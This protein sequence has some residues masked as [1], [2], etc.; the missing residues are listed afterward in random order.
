MK[1]EGRMLDRGQDQ[2]AEPEGAGLWETRAELGPAVTVALLLILVALFLLLGI[3][4]KVDGLT[5]LGLYLSIAVQS[6]GYAI[7][8]IAI[9]FPRE[10]FLPGLLRIVK[11]PEF[12]VLGVAIGFLFVRL[13]PVLFAIPL[14]VVVLVLV[15]GAWGKARTAL[16]PGIYLL[17]GLLTAFGYNVVAVTLRFKP[18]YDSVLRRCDAIFLAG[19][20]VSE[21][22]HR[23]AAMMPS[24]VTE[25]L[26]VWYAMM[27]AEIGATLILCSVLIDRQYAMKFVTTILVAYAITVSF[28][29]LFPTH[30][31]Y[32]TCV[33]HTTSALPRAMLQIQE[34]FIR[35]AMARGSGAKFPLGPEYYISF[36]CMHI[37]Q[38]LIAM[39]FLRRWKRIF[40]FLFAVNLILAF[41]IVILEWHYF[42]DLL[43]GGFVAGLS[44]WL[45]NRGRPLVASAPVV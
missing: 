31:P 37:A 6:S 1:V 15:Q 32:F 23:F 7:L 30:S 27:F 21:L 41:A 24:F 42:V 26:L 11:R 17:L 18:N 38:P 22:S 44:I 33:D 43:G 40:W 16:I 5:L 13:L 2:V 36:P 39:W 35:T 45:V 4:L 25:G 28:F 14:L 20:S 19:H 12:I 34:Q 10:L 9:Q 29:F 8:L 3:S